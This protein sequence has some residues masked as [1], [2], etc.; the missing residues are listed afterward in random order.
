MKLKTCNNCDSDLRSWL[1]WGA[2]SILESAETWKSN[3]L[4][5]DSQFLISYLPCSFS[6]KVWT[7]AN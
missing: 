5:H 7:E 4:C 6:I 1:R 2:N 3:A